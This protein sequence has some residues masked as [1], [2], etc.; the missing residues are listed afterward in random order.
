MKTL[1]AFL[2]ALALVTAATAQTTTPI[3]IN[4][5]V[6]GLN[7][8]TIE[9]TDLGLF[10]PVGSADEAIKR[11]PAL[12][13]AIK[14]AIEASLDGLDEVAAAKRVSEAN[15]KGIVLSKA[16]SDKHAK[17]LKDFIADREPKL[18]KVALTDP[19]RAAQKMKEYLDAG[20]QIS[21]ATQDAVAAAQPMPKSTPVPTPQSDGL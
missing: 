17:R 3:K 20:I 8:V 2:Y 21:K 15:A 14:A 5:T 16:A 7:Y 13:P 10:Q 1:T 12:A 19:T 6:D 9:F 4:L 18:K 11:Y